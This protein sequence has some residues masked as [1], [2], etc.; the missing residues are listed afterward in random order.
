MDE[1]EEN[2]LV[3]LSDEGATFLEAAFG[4]KLD[5]NSRKAKAKAQGIPNSRWIRCA[6]I[7]PVVSANVPP[8]ARTADGCERTPTILARRC[9]PAGVYPGEG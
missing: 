1:I 3:T 7:D 4:S 9:Q 5:N 2:E 8:A 6:K